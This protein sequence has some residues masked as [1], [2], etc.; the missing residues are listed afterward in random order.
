MSKL[1]A[2]GITGEPHQW[3]SSHLKRREQYCQITGGRSS[4]RV[5]QCRIPH[6]SSSGPVLFIIYV[7]DLLHCLS[8]SSP[9]M[10]EYFATVTYSADDI[11]TL[12]DDL[13]EELTNI[14]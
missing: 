14:S 7:N 9:N 3:F 8:R 1:A 12:C 11:K 10:Y 4:R 13:N 2:Y 6:G 5:I